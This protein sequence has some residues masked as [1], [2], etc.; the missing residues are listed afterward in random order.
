MA[1]SAAAATTTLCANDLGS[2]NHA[3]EHLDRAAP[4]FVMTSQRHSITTTM[5]TRNASIGRC[6]A[7]LFRMRLLILRVLRHVL[8]LVDQ[9][10]ARP[11]ILSGSRIV[12]WQQPSCL[13]LFLTCLLG[14]VALILA[15]IQTGMKTRFPW[16]RTLGLSSIYSFDAEARVRH[17]AISRNHLRM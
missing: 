4:G 16:T 10:T 12:H 15:P 9:N 7:L 6:G 8:G 17:L 11:T 5:E 14:A 2:Q 1:S 13:R 3:T